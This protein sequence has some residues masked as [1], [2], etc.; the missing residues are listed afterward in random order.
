MKRVN[1]PL[2]IFLLLVAGTVIGIA[3][4]D[5]VLPAIPGLPRALGGTLG[6][7]QLVLAA[8]TAGAGVGL[9]AFGE[10]G[11]RYDRRNLLLISLISFGVVSALAC[12]ATSMPMLIALRALQG[13]A[14]SAA[15]VFAPGVVSSIYGK[16][17]AVAKLGL[18]GSV[19]SMAPAFAPILG[20]WLLAVGDWRAN[21]IVLSAAAFLLAIW[22][23]WRMAPIAPNQQ[24]QGSHGY[25]HL[26]VNYRF[27]RQALSHA[28]TLGAL[29][30]FVFGAPTV[31]THRLAGTLEDF[32]YMQLFGITFFVIASNV[33]GRLVTRYGAEPVILGGTAL[34]AF[35]GCSLLLYGLVGGTSLTVVTILFLALNAGLGFRGPPG[36]HAAVVESEGDDA[37]G[38]ALV[39]LAILGTTS[40][41]TAIVAIFIEDGLI[42]LAG[43]SAALALIALLLCLRKPA[44]K[45]AG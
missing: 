7:A 26:M 17:R 11:A 8:F 15:A 36:F 33:T 27:Q 20:L 2:E 23:A 43:A 41:G 10:L 14:G 24:V 12:F 6:Q 13:A 31:F 4:T 3:G 40:I 16:E 29:L 44:P 42:P 38:A 39:V 5:L 28:C 45:I 32:I 25:H 37:R 18:L 9:L 22:V 1:A 19:E 30:V 34:S 21:F 35:G